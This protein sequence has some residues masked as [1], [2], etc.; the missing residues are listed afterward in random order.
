ML[1]MRR[2]R[3]TEGQ[4]EQGT[5]D[6]A[7]QLRQRFSWRTL[8]LRILPRML[9]RMLLPLIAYQVL[10]HFVPMA[11]WMTLG[12]AA[13]V[14][15]F[16]IV[17]TRLRT[18]SFDILSVLM[19]SGL[20]FSLLL[21]LFTQDSSLLSLR[22]PLLHGLFGIICLGSLA[23]PQPLAWTVYTYVMTGRIFSRGGWLKEA[24]QQEPSVLSTFRLV[25]LVAGCVLIGVAM[26]HV[27]L[28]F[29]LRGLLVHGAAHTGHGSL[30]HTN[31]RALLRLLARFMISVG[32]HILDIGADI[33]LGL[34]ALRKLTA[35]HRRLRAKFSS[36]PTQ[37]L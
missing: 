37:A 17:F 7:K 14:P 21:S 10:E 6:R 5:Q 26:V 2:F 23:F 35:A 3:R 13:T 34:W 19:L 22:E 31:P 33:L 32:R 25:T 4:E 8:L 16:F 36:L 29:L 18:R 9:L 24:L 27:S 20:A 28:L 30:L 11:E 1:H 15:L 12:I